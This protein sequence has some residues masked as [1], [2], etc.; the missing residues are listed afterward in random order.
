MDARAK[1][2]QEDEVTT[3][4]EVFPTDETDRHQVPLIRVVMR[5]SEGREDDVMSQPIQEPSRL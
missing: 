1:G 5:A 3:R 4:L 2:R